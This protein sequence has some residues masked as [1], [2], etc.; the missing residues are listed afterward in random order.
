M[1]RRRLLLGAAVVLGLSA[2]GGVAPRPEPVTK[3]P[4]AAKPRPKVAL[5]LGGGAARGFAHIGVIKAL[6][7]QGIIPDVIVGTSAGA[8]AEEMVTLRSPAAA[9]HGP[10]TIRLRARATFGASTTPSS[11]RPMFSAKW[12]IWIC[13]F[14]PRLAP[15]FRLRRTISRGIAAADR[16]GESGVDSIP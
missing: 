5:A 7:A 8:T 4:V 13:R 3:P 16:M 6:E 2:C 12:S 10:R 1:K 14:Q 9:N 11:T 15:C